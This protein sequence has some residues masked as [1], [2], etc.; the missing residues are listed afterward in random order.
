MLKIL[1]FPLGYCTR[2]GFK[3]NLGRARGEI[4]EKGGVS[5][6]CL[7]LVYCEAGVDAGG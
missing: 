3:T 6:A 5:D 7:Q 4:V 1:F 2:I